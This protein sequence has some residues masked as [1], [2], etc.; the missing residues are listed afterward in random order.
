MRRKNRAAYRDVFS[1]LRNLCPGMRPGLILT[2]FER[3]LQ[4]A[5]KD[6]FPECIVQGCW[7]HYIRVRKCLNTILEN[8]YQTFF[9][10][11]IISCFRR[12]CEIAPVAGSLPI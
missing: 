12:Y 9:S 2:D 3:A 1:F 6:V 8:Y 11:I 10:I 4:A 5:L 7:F